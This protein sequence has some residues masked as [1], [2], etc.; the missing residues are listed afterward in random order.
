ML[1]RSPWGHALPS[2]VAA[3]RLLLH[4]QLTDRLCIPRRL[5]DV[6]DLTRRNRQRRSGCSSLLH[7]DDRPAVGAVANFL[8]LIVRLDLEAQLA[9]VDLQQLGPDP[10]LLALGRG[11]E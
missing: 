7:L 6:L 3:Q 9:A 8:V 1:V 5:A 11:A 2:I 4:R 10:D